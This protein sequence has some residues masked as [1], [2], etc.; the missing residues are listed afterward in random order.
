MPV[1]AKEASS[2]GWL[3]R[4]LGLEQL[5]SRNRRAT[6]ASARLEEVTE[7]LERTTKRLRDLI[8][9]KEDTGG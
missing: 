9:E 6:L 4:A 5:D 3:A 8:S 2:V 1:L 7:E